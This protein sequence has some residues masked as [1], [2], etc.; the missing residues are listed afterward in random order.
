MPLKNSLNHIHYS[1]QIKKIKIKRL[2]MFDLDSLFYT[3]IY[4]YLNTNTITVLKEIIVNVFRKVFS[5]NL[6]NDHNNTNLLF[7]FQ[8]KRVDH[9][10]YWLTFKSIFDSY[11]ELKLDYH[12]KKFDRYFLKN[13]FFFIGVLYKLKGFS[14]HIRLSLASKALLARKITRSLESLDMNYRYVFTFFDGGF[15]GNL[16]AQFFKNKSSKTV[17]L[18]HGQ[19][20]YRK[21]GDRLNQSVIMNFISDYCICKGEFA[22]QQYIKA[23]HPSSKVYALGDLNAIKLNSLKYKEKKRLNCFCVFLDA[24][25][26]PFFIDSTKLL[27]DFSE[28]FAIKNGYKF[29]IKPHPAMKNISLIE[30]VDKKVCIDILDQNINLSLINEISDFSIFH[31]SAIYA[32]LLIRR[33]KSFKLNSNIDFDIVRNQKDLFNNIEDL[34]LKILE[35]ENLSLIKKKQYFD[36]EVE[37]YSNPS[38]ILKRYKN[39]IESL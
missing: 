31:A 19:S 9:D 4:Y 8:Y 15:E 3:S 5:L 23:G 14:Y 30:S 29:F 16:I 34:V 32:D 37:Y 27:L 13:I 17:T 7:T 39:F 20:L 2:E 1:E 36:I 6:N 12:N 38:L 35:W 24:P 22:R 18:Q 10:D 21:D 33:I 26:Y 11:S 28:K 25:G